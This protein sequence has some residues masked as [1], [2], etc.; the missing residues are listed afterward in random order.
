M[1]GFDR[2]LAS[3]L[4]DFVWQGTL[5]GVMLLAGLYAARRQ[6]AQV[7]YGL[8]AAAMLVLIALPIVTAASRYERTDD[9]GDAFTVAQF[10]V[11]GKD[12]VQ[13]VAEVNARPEPS[14]YL[15]A[16]QPWVL[17]LWSLGV[18]LLSLRLVAGGLAVRSLRRS[19]CRADDRLRER[20]SQLA[21][22]MGIGRPVDVVTSVRSE[23]PGAI[24]WLRPLILLPPATMMGL[25]A[26]Q[27]DAVLAHELAHIRRHDYLVNLVQMVAETLLF[28]HPVVWWVSHHL[29]VER[30]L[31]CDDEAVRVSGDRAAY[32]RALVTMAKSQNPAMAMG[33][34]GGSLR[35]R[36]HRLLGLGGHETRRPALLAVA[37]IAVALISI[38][39]AGVDAQSTRARF[40]VAS[41]KFAAP[42]DRPGWVAFL[43]GG[44]VRGTAVPLRFVISRAYDV[45]WKQLEGESDL[46]NLR[47]TIQARADVRALPAQGS[48]IE[49]TIRA[50]SPMLREMLQTLLL[51][52]FKLAIHRETRDSPIY[53]LVVGPKGHKL[54]RAALN[55]DPTTV[56][57][58]E[59]GLGPC[60][61]QGGGPANG[62]RMR[63]A[64][65]SDLAAA[66]SV[67]LDRTV[68]DRTGVSGRFDIDVPPWS[69][70]APPR[71]DS[72]EPQP[73]PDGP[74]IFAVLQQFGLRL[75]PARGPI[76]YYVVDHV[77][78]PSEN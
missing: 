18:V 69:T 7:R 70:G 50:H 71:L 41:V 48:T 51:E 2:A 65:L 23:G 47:Y 39:L 75:E 5:V 74:S 42:Q 60:G 52:R 59:S 35:D 27:L 56:E 44:L 28:Y 33:V 24:G 15:I 4:V 17:P 37:A 22:T 61:R 12:A 13:R 40:E 11:V 29:R 3:A 31:C 45:P 43:P 72:D 10:T 14:R 68:V 38:T 58:A 66:L 53:A 78:R 20:V 55:C 8:S 30:E 16:L 26:T 25:T 19:A 63:S 77:E 49:S 64:E 67:F 6:S 9:R 36:V 54:T 34:A 76:D 21:M 62:Y 32:A 46:L 73:D 57:E 1:N